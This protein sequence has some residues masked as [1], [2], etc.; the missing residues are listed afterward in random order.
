MVSIMGGNETDYSR[1]Q[2]KSYERIQNEFG[3][4][5]YNCKDLDIQI[6][7]VNERIATE[8][9]KSPSPDLPSKLYQDLLQA[10]KNAWEAMWDGKGCRDIIENIRLESMAVAETSS[11]IRQEKDVLGK[12]NKDQN[13]YIGVGAVVV[14]IG[15]YIVLKK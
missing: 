7:R 8:L 2:E 9:M 12:S 11:A 5:P 3:N 1:A 13:I 14:L 10:K 6:K 15:L 4:L